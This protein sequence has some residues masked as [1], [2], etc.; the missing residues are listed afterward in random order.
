M[1]ITNQINREIAFF[2]DKIEY[3][4]IYVTNFDC[5]GKDIETLF[6]NEQLFNKTIYLKIERKLK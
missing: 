5:L 2:S 6:W 1:K 4:N 3:F